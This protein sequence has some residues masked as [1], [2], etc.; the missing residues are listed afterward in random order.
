MFLLEN[1]YCTFDSLFIIL[2]RFLLDNSDKG[3]RKLNIYKMKIIRI[4]IKMKKQ[5]KNKVN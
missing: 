1:K 2:F 4:S 5:N 3:W